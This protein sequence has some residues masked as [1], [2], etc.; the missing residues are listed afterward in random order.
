MSAA[1]G[2]ALTVRIRDTPELQRAHDLMAMITRR[3]LPVA[4]DISEK[5]RLEMEIAL[6]LLCWVLHHDRAAIFNDTLLAME[7]TLLE[8]GYERIEEG[9]RTYILR[10]G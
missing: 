10:K 1:N 9:G 6:D 4:V 2:R 7:E 3:D 5:D 8:A